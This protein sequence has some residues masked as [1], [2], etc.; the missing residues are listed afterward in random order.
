MNRDIL[1]GTDTDQS[2]SDCTLIGHDTIF[3][4]SI[5]EADTFKSFLEIYQKIREKGEGRVWLYAMGNGGDVDSGLAIVDIIQLDGEFSGIL[6]GEALS[7]H[8]F[9]WAACQDRYVSKNGSLGLHHVMVV[10]EGTQM[11]HYDLDILSRQMKDMNMKIIQLYQ[12]A[13][14]QG[15]NFWERIMKRNESASL[16]QLNADVLIR[17]DMAM[18]MMVEQL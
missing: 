6:M 3:L 4:P 11:N 2:D 5:I 16:N 12:D 17:I 13:S 1:Y 9:I 14:N 15:E 18:K 7:T 8:G 10:G